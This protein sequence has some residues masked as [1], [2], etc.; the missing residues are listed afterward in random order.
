MESRSEI[1]NMI[2]YKNIGNDLVEEQLVKCGTWAEKLK[3]EQRKTNQQINKSITESSSE[4]TQWVKIPA[5]VSDDLN[6]VPNTHINKG[7]RELSF[8]L[9][10]T[11]QLKPRHTYYIYIK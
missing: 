2:L 1:G 10:V 7:E 8:K 6:S 4:I 5:T 11:S 3:T 9:P